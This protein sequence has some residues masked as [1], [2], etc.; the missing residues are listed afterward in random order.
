MPKPRNL[1]A[2][3]SVDTADV[4][5]KMVIGNVERGGKIRRIG[6]KGRRISLVLATVEV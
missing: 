1:D 2:K 6:G 3:L 5:L 4:V